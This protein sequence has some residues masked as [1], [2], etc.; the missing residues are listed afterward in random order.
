MKKDYLN[1]ST[2][3]LRDVIT[4]SYRAKKVLFALGVAVVV[5]KLVYLP[6]ISTRLINLVPTYS[7]DQIALVVTI[8]GL[9]IGWKVYDRVIR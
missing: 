8:I 4:V 3:F 6:T 7:P 9:I 5:S 2:Y 1:S